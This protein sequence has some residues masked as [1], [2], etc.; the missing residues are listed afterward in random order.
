MSTEKQG[1]RP[2]QASAQDEPTA[3]DF[4]GALDLLLADGALGVLRRLRP[5]GAGL[6]LAASLVRRPELVS[7]QAA[8]LAV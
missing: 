1:Q 3:G 2:S 4:A 6:R 7:Q 5:D 8:A